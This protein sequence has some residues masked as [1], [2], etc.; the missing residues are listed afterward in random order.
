[1]SED[2]SE[3]ALGPGSVAMSEPIDEHERLRRV[4]RLYVHHHAQVYGLALRYGAG[5]RGWAEDVTQEVFV[6]LLDH[7]DE[8]DDVDALAGWL[9]RVT[10]NCCLMRLRRGRL[11][12]LLP[13]PGSLTDRTVDPESC[14]W[15]RQELRRVLATV[16]RLPPKQRVVLCMHHLDGKRQTEIAQILGYSRG[17][18]SKLL[19]RAHRR[20]RDQGWDVDD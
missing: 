9:Y 2:S 1:M 3:L 18:V 20:V 10:C 13:L 7:F 17:Y 4:E 19:D 5:D 14:T 6:K 11:R 12:R 8:L 16:E 15:V